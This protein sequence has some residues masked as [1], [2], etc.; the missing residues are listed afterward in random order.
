MDKRLMPSRDEGDMRA[1][2]W[3]A[4]LQRFAEEVR[5][6]RR[7]VDPAG[8]KVLGQALGPMADDA[9]KIVE[10]Y[11][12]G[13]ADASAS[14]QLPA[15]FGNR[16]VIILNGI[17]ASLGDRRSARE[18]EAPPH[19]IQSELWQILRRVRESAELSYAREQELIELDRRILFLLQNPGPL[20]PA[21][22]SSAVG[23][24]KAQVSRSVKRLLALGLV[25]REQIRAPL[26]LTREGDKLMKRMLRMAE[27]RNRE[28]TIE[29]GE[30][31]LNEFYATVEVLLDRAMALYEQ[32]REI[33]Q[34]GR[35]D[36]AGKA[37]DGKASERIAIDRTRIVSPLMTLSSYFSRSGALAFKRLT[38][39]STFEA[40][41][42][43]EIGMRAPIDWPTL[44]AQ[45]QRD[46]SQAGRTVRAL[47]ERGLVTREGRPGRR[48]GRF[49][50]TAEG[51]RLYDIIQETSVER[52]TFLMA[53]LGDDQ[54]ERFLAVFDKLRRNAVAQ[55]QRERAFE[56]LDR[57]G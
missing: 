42:L 24:D 17:E 25:E 45:L 7:G 13:A 11:A 21:D 49:S 27:L 43:S 30:D 53:P 20:V 37:A 29:I 14:A 50:P 2:D 22:I 23:V 54:R 8:A 56:E 39:L 57:E 38:G 10:A 3:R 32:E 19:V 55:L 44:T 33:A 31:E 15:E 5:Q 9:F 36:G 46:H 34:G 40:F 4:V 41:V 28:L 48:H 51:W 18:G 35:S 1:A 52:S 12:R 47:I 16:L 6:G 26:R